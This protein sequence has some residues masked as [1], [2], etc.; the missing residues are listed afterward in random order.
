MVVHLIQWGVGRPYKNTKERRK[1]HSRPSFK[2]AGSNVRKTALRTLSLCSFQ[3]PH[4]LPSI[5]TYTFNC[6]SFSPF[7][8]FMCQLASPWMIMVIMFFPILGKCC[9]VCIMP[10]WLLTRG[11]N[12]ADWTRPIVGRV[13][14]GSGQNWPVFS[15]QN[16][17]S[18]TRPKKGVGRVK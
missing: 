11:G 4:L 15:Y 1:V 2:I 13:K 16:F 17:N 3:T 5:T 12:R 6:F 7:Y 14:T 8:L 10:E 18:P 9:F